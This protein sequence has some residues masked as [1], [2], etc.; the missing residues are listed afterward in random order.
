[1]TT[2]RINQVTT[3]PDRTDYDDEAAAADQSE[4]LLETLLNAEPQGF[5]RRSFLRDS[6]NTHTHSQSASTEASAFADVSVEDEPL[7][8]FAF[9]T[10]VARSEY[11]RLS[12]FI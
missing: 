7:F 3:E 12:E 5:A 8:Q 9:R 1:M 10:L 6:R 2:G 4:S 11:S